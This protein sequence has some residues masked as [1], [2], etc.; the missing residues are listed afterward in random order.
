MAIVVYKTYVVMCILARFTKFLVDGVCGAS[1]N[2]HV[3]DT[4]CAL[5]ALMDGILY[6]KCLPP[7]VKGDS[8][9]KLKIAIPLGST[10]SGCDVAILDTNEKILELAEN[11]D[12]VFWPTAMD[13][14]LEDFEKFPSKGI[15]ISIFHGPIR[16]S[17]HLH[18]AKLAREKSKILVAFGACACFGGVF[19]LVNLANR[20][21]VFN[22]VYSNTITTVNPEGKKPEKKIV[23]DG[24]E[25]TLPE[26]FDDSRPVNAVVD[27][28]Y[29]LPGCP[30]S[31]TLIS[32][33]ID[34][35]INYAKKG[36]LPPKGTVLGSQ[37]SLCDECPRKRENK[38]IFDIYR[39]HE[40]IP[41]P[42]KCLLE[43]GIICLGPATRGG[44]GVQCITANMPCRGCMGPLPNVTDQGAKMLSALASIV[45]VGKEKELGEDGLRKILEKIADPVGTFYRYTLPSG[46]IGKNVKKQR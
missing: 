1:S 30:P 25:L 40:K 24:M 8:M 44:C 6:K 18:M 9:E 12:I 32:D 39:V 23:I 7:S 41:E 37:K 20:E 5:S 15:D 4:S 26:W 22:E 28:D 21:E 13:F 46:I 35:A 16:T 3:E 14:K 11:A 38:A 29:Y 45:G 34:I 33:L 31:P 2:S 19:G 43:Q 27:V 36:E 17:E 42:E 10:C